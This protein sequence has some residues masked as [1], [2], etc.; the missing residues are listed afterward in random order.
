MSSRMGVARV[1]VLVRRKRVRGRE[2]GD[3]M[4]GKWFIWD[5]NGEMRKF[6]ECWL[7]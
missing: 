2:R 4:A 3:F 7:D 5:W 1:V 6:E